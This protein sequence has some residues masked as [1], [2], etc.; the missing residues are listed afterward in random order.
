LIPLY[1]VKVAWAM[2]K[3]IE[4]PYLPNNIPYFYRFNVR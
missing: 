2:R 1:Q 3:N 4:A